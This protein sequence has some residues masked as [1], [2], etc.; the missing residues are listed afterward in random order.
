MNMY[1][2][3]SVDIAIEYLDKSWYSEICI[4]NDEIAYDKLAAFCKQVLDGEILQWHT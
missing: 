2:R 4:F 3:S 1:Q